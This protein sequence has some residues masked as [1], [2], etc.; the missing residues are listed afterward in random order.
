MK[1]KKP[2]KTQQVL[3]IVVLVFLVGVLATGL[4]VFNFVIKSIN[5][6]ATK[7]EVVTMEIAKGAT[8][9]ASIQALY[10]A[11]LINDVMIA[12]YYA[13]YAKL[14][15]IKAGIYRLD[16]AWTLKAILLKINDPAGAV[17]T[18]V[19]LTIVPG[20]WARDIA[21]KIAAK[22]NHDAAQL[23]ALWNDDAYIDE[24]SKTYSVITTDVKKSGT[25][26]KLEGYLFPETYFIRADWSMKKVTEKLIAQTQ[27]VYEK[28]K[29]EFDATKLVPHN[30][31]THQVFILASITQFEASKEADM[32]N[33]AQVFYNRLKQNMLLQSSV[34]ICYAL[35]DYTDW[36]ACES[37][38][39]IDSKYNTYKYP[40][41]PIGPITNSSETAINAVL[42]PTPNDYLYFIADI[43][44]NGTVYF[45]KTF[46]EHEANVNKYLK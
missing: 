16:K 11:K 26:V 24:L 2:K 23:L 45:A 38:P 4:F 46:A 10:D 43:Y 30:L 15:A 25:R 42:N 41:L 12:K 18:D 32:K 20:D 3:R 28:H 13:R 36:R 8:L 14:T 35:Y 37:N 39:T 6:I 29:A 9:D 21:K 5:P 34:T 44:G 27:S 19:L 31:S 33:V 17:S 22:T 1:N 40:G 7:S